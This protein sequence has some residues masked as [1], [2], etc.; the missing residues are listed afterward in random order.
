MSRSFRVHHLDD[1]ATV[2]HGRSP[3][4]GVFALLGALG[5]SG[6]LLLPFSF[7]WSFG[8]L[9]LTVAVVVGLGYGYRVVIEPRGITIQSTWLGFGLPCSREQ[10][11][12]DAIVDD[13]LP[14]GS[15]EIEGVGIGCE[16][17]PAPGRDREA[18]KEA[19]QSAIGRA[20]GCVGPA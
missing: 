6:L 5:M 16:C 14:W 19:L 17:L 18:L 1:H 2:I 13:Y 3:G 7:G 20:R 12:L 8:L 10:A 9:G 11:E 15:E 4:L